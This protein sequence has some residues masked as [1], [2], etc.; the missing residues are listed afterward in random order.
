MLVYI[1]SSVILNIIINTHYKRTHIWF[2]KCSKLFINIDIFV[3][4][5]RYFKFYLVI[6]KIF[7][8]INEIQ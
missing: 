7:D 3:G 2:N 6:I 5:Q 8:F 4:W 1:F